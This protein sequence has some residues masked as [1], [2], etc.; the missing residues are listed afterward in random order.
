MSV[1]AFARTEK[2]TL[3]LM[4]FASSEMLPP[5]A[6]RNTPQG[7]QQKTARGSDT[8]YSRARAVP[9]GVP[10]H[11]PIHLSANLPQQVAARSPPGP[12][13]SGRDSKVEPILTGHG[14]NSPPTASWGARMRSR[15]VPPRLSA[16]LQHRSLKARAAPSRQLCKRGGVP[17]WPPHPTR[18]PPPITG[19]SPVAESSAWSLRHTR[20]CQ[21]NQFAWASR[22][23]CISKRAMRVTPVKLP[24][25]NF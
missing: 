4:A 22:I 20:R 11:R 24:D 13:G 8:N 12:P 15:V 9:T 10:R 21:S 19:G 23:A 17:N 7:K 16:K 14:P 6:R 5:P 1:N 18:F 25:R 3:K 2:R